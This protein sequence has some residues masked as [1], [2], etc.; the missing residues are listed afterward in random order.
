MKRIW[1]F[2]FALILTIS[3]IGCSGGKA[4]DTEAGIMGYVMDKEKDRI[5]AVSSDAQDFSSTGGVEEFYDAIWFSEAPKDIEIGDKV[6]V[7][8]DIVAESYPGQSKVEHIEV[9]PAEKPD[10]ADLSDSEALHKALTSQ[11]IDTNEVLAVKSIEFD[12][13]SDSWNI[14]LKEVFSGKI[15][16]VKVEDK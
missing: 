10:G 9:I 11:S 3:L 8:F 16:E 6:K 12:S 2:I 5:L 4:P 13:Q 15:H 7:W 1:S 14:K